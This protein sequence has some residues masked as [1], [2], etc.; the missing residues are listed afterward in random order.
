MS[1]R[2][3]T[4]VLAVLLPGGRSQNEP[5]R[6]R[7]C[8]AFFGLH[9]GVYPEIEQVAESAAVE[10]RFL[11]DEAVRQRR[12][13]LDGVDVLLVQHLRAADGEQLAELI[14]AARRRTPGF[15]A[16]MLTARQP[17]ALTSQPEHQ[18]LLA[19]DPALSRYYATSVD[20]L[21]RLLRYVA[22]RYCGAKG[23]IEPPEPARSVGL[24]HPDHE[25]VLDA[26][27]MLDFLEARNP[28]AKQRPRAAVLVH[29]IHLDF[30]QPEVVEAIV[31]RLEQEGMTA[32]VVIDT[33]EGLGDQTARYEELLAAAKPDVVVHTCHSRDRVSLRVRLDVPHL[34]SMFFR[35]KSIDEWRA[36]KDGIDPQEIAFHVTGQEPLG[37]IE[38]HACAGPLVGGGTADSFVPIPDRIDKL[39]RRASAWARLRRTPSSEKRIAIFYWD[40]EMDKGGLMRG[41]ATGM[42]L[43]APRSI[44]KLLA[45]MRE[46]GYEV[47]HLPDEKQLVAEMIDHGRQLPVDDQQELARLVHEGNPVL[48]PVERYNQ[49]LARRVPASARKKLEERWGPAPGRFMVWRDAG[50]RAFFVVPR[51]DFGGVVLLPQP[52]RGE[53]HDSS[54]AHDKL[55]C[56]PHQY[57]ATYFWLEEELHANAVVHFGTHGSEFMLP[58]KSVGLSSDDWP[59]IVLG[60]LPNV[61]PWIVENLGEAAPAKRRVYALTIGHQPPPLMKAGLADGLSSLHDDLEKWATLAPGTLKEKFRDAIDRAVRAQKLDRDLHLDLAA[62]GRIDDAQIQAV[63]EYL[64]S[65]LEEK[66]PNRLHV[67]GEAPRKQDLIP[68]IVCCLRKPFTDALA[69]LLDNGTQTTHIAWQAE[70]LVRL[71]L[72]RGLEPREAVQVVTDREPSELPEAITKG[73]EV[74]RELADGYAQSGREVTAILDALD[75]RFVEPGP[76]RGPDRNPGVLPTGR[77]L[78]ML[79]PDEVPS[80]PSW[81]LGR[82]LADRL[83]AQQKQKLGHWPKKVAFSISSFATFQD[84]GVMEAQILRTIGVEPI[85]NAKNLVL[86]FRIT[87]REVLGRPRV[88]VFCAALSY[89]RDN[90]PSRMRLLDD[91]IR[92]V[93]AI[94]EPNNYLR[95]NAL[96]AERALLARQIPV[97]RAKKLAR[98]R[99]YGYAPG[100]VSDPSYYYLVERS[101]DWDTREELMERYMKRVSHVYTDDLW[102]EPAREGYEEAIRGSEIV[103]RTWY[104]SM[105]S[106]LSNKYTWYTGGSLALAI[107][108]V[109]GKRPE[110]V[111]SDVRDVD[112]AGLL[113]AEDAMHRDLRTRLFNRKW[114][115]GMQKEGYAGANQVAVYVKNLYG[116]EIMRSGSIRPDMWEQVKSV[117]FDD[118]LQMGLRRWFDEVNPFA[119]QEMAEVMLEA[120]RKGYWKADPALLREIAQTLLDSIAEHGEA[121][122]IFEAGKGK[123][124]AFA[125]QQV[126]PKAAEASAEP[127]GRVAQTPE[128]AEDPT[129]VTDAPELVEGQ[130]LVPDDSQPETPSALLPLLG[131]AGL[132]L[133]VLIGFVR[134]EPR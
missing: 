126:A 64:H 108:H 41:S 94:D 50:G 122:G 92:A 6:E 76:G 12:A 102:G 130:K 60:D 133:L 31:R 34:H 95:E 71:V 19:C 49:W 38:P 125:E 91:A 88:D 32:F 43:N 93:I 66:V 1:L 87:P 84:Y 119:L 73:I 85:W 13:S 105:T 97:S 10:V 99:V 53:A 123:T 75:G 62:G 56:P 89:Y 129:P 117:F 39:V 37:A 57:L 74:A 120:A 18:G 15:Q 55:T 36:S 101:G 29:S 4:V 127:R 5:A 9:G 115:A 46:H 69:G 118:R 98:A 28:G 72:E 70:K 27:G 54:S 116:W 24:W 106:P 113:D 7:P 63:D 17:P 134:G 90:F 61:N 48:I 21:R 112:R 42:Y 111:L 79:S 104:D 14:L 114:I 23:E 68:S 26:E 58:G 100:S 128:G 107:E 22:I 44:V 96:A 51:L 110:Y 132:L 78:Y 124:R 65:I 47:E 35:N 25:G 109:S 103:L 81:E 33:S 121:A 45:A 40:R 131:A 83:L 86:E 67:L 16:L 30:Q 11:S 20:N 52:M 80:R 77:N 8:I 82:E 3:A 59:D 2:I